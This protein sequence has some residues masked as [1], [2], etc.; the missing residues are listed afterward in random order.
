MESNKTLIAKIVK[1]WQEY[2]RDS[3][4]TKVSVLDVLLLILKAKVNPV[5]H[6]SKGNNFHSFI[7]QD[8]TIQNDRG[9]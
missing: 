7:T 9:L 4:E 1:V 6:N 5:L 2:V 3:E 8:L